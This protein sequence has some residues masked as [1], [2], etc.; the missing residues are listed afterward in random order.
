MHQHHWYAVVER[1]GHLDG[2]RLRS[3]RRIGVDA[4]PTESTHVYQG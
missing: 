3:R 2:E 1:P 4:G